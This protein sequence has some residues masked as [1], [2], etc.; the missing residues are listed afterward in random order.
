MPAKRSVN[1]ML[2]K[3]AVLNYVSYISANRQGPPSWVIRCFET[4]QIFTS[5]EKAALEMGIHK[6][7]TSRRTSRYM[8]Q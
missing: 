6:M 3:N 5:Q 7:N 4:D 2:G 8:S 1:V